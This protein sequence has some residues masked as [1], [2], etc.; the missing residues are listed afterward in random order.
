MPEYLKTETSSQKPGAGGQK[1]RYYPIHLDIQNR[2]CL[3]VGG[4]AVAT[5]KVVKLLEC[6]AKVTVVS[7]EMS[8]KILDLGE[9]EHL[10]IKQRP[11]Q[12]GDLAGMFLVIGATDDEIL[13]RQIS[14]DAE[15]RNTL[16]NIADRPEVCNFI[17]PSIIQRD[18]LVITISTSGRSPAMAKKLRKTLEKQFGEEYGELLRLMGAVRQKL[19]SQAH[20][21]EAHKPLFEQLIESDLIALIRDK[22]SED[23]DALL[24]KVLGAG[25][26]FEELME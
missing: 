22:K 18:D 6:G 15:V 5:R 23:I 7:P 19:L 14:K 17:L 1:M 25:Y 8:D 13:N 10:K 26:R 20:E 9:S 2:N 4:G 16:C 24:F 3:V 11:Y 12:A 21:P